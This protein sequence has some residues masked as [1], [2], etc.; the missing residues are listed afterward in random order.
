MKRVT[1]NKKMKIFF[2]YDGS[3]NIRPLPEVSKI[4]LESIVFKQ[5]VDR[6][7]ASGIKTLTIHLHTLGQWQS[8]EGPILTPNEGEV[9][10]TLR[11]EVDKQNMPRFR[12]D[13]LLARYQ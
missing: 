6:E 5:Q 13:F 7:M 9:S 2:E 10:D 3:D 12:R 4:G 8:Y 1:L 11:F